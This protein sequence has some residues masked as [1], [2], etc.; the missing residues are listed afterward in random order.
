MNDTLKLSILVLF[1]VLLAGCAG[2]GKRPD[3]PRHFWRGTLVQNAQGYWFELCGQTERHPVAM[4]AEPLKQEYVRQSL[5]DGWP[6]YIEA[7]GHVSAQGVELSDPV[8][9]GGSLKACDF[10]LPGIKL[11]AVSSRD[12][13]IIDLRERQ[14]RVHFQDSLRQLGFNRPEA[15]R[16][17]GVRR[18]QDSMSTRGGQRSHQLLLDVERRH[19]EGSSGG[20]YALTMSAEVDGRFYKGCARLGDLE[21]WRLFRSYRSADELTTRRLSL[22]LEP[23]GSALL[24]EDYLNQQPVIERSGRWQQTE[25]GVV[26][27]RLEPDPSGSVSQVLNF[28][29][30]LEGRL[31]LTHFHPAYG[32]ALELLPAGEPMMQHKDLDWWR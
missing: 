16:L 2:A 26:Q 11:R 22:R 25:I 4:L 23:D 21:Q 5:G 24:L 14:V 15:V 17:G 27:L 10:H 31:K 8:L 12:G 18:W 3:E 13:A 30:D 7:F 19:C 20:W 9:M 1:S 28:R 6:V 29:L 32:R